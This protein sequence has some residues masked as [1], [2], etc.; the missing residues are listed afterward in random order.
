MKKESIGLYFKEEKKPWVPSL[1]RKWGKPHPPHNPSGSA[2]WIWGLLQG[3][4]WILFYFYG[5]WLSGGELKDRVSGRSITQR[6]QW[7]QSVSK[8]SIGCFGIPP[9]LSKW[10]MDPGTVRR[11]AI[12]IYIRGP[13][14][15]LNQGT[16]GICYLN[17]KQ[18][19]QGAERREATR[20]EEVDKPIQISIGQ[21]HKA[22]EP[23]V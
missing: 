7:M 10:M 21:R 5:K 15:S 17:D 2:C 12:L 19:P 3:Q 1:S 9:L 18:L 13:H 22:P 11:A 23:W 14:P 6:D 20:R 16:A 4:G 8:Q